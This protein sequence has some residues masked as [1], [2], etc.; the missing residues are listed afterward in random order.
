MRVESLYL[1]FLSDQDRRLKNF[2]NSIFMNHPFSEMSSVSEKLNAENGE[3][4]IRS[5]IDTYLRINQV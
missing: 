1:G 2:K 3:S 5:K 4:E